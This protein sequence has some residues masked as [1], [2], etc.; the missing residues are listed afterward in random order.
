MRTFSFDPELIGGK[1][2][3]EFVV[4]S[5]SAASTP[6][7]ASKNTRELLSYS[8]TAWTKTIDSLFV[9]RITG[10]S[11][12]S[13]AAAVRSIRKSEGIPLVVVMDLAATGIGQDMQI[14]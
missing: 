3:D 5:Q 7:A 8:I 10:I 11:M 4:R 14:S 2:R 1:G 6:G 12:I 9:L 13:P